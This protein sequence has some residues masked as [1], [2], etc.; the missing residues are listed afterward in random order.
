MIFTCIWGGVNPKGSV[1]NANTRAFY[2]HGMETSNQ[3]V[4]NFDVMT[5]HLTSCDWLRLKSQLK[6]VS[7]SLNVK[8]NHDFFS[9]EMRDVSVRSG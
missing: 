9:G 6:D 8:K 5:T 4:E 2:H 1:L 7:E 3:A